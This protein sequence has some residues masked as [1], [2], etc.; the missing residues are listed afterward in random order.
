MQYN[1][2]PGG[3]GVAPEE[4]QG[5]YGGYGQQNMLQQL[6]PGLLAQPGGIQALLAMVPQLASLLLPQF[7]QGLAPGLMP[8]GQQQYDSSLMG[9]IQDILGQ[10]ALPGLPGGMHPGWGAQQPMAPMHPAWQQPQ[11]LPAQFIRPIP[12]FQPSY[13]GGSC[14]PFPGASP[15]PRARELVLGFTSGVAVPHG[16]TA[17]ITNRPQVA[18]QGKRLIV[19]SNVAPHFIIND[20][21]VGKDSQFTASGPVPAVTFQENAVGVALYIDPALIA[22]DISLN[23][24]NIAE[25]FERDTSPHRETSEHEHRHHRHR[26]HGHR[27]WASLIGDSC[28]A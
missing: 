9:S 13:A 12:R 8:Y 27:F 14:L 3:G 10:T 24:T 21:K 6:L 17:I 5:A 18:M 15:G 25:H 7:A 26:H 11:F 19:P 23:V 2:A 4:M 16:A 20:L 22:Q 1:V 28:Q